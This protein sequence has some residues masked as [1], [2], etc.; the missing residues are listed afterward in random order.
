MRKVTYYLFFTGSALFLLFACTKSSSSTTLIGNWVNRFDFAG[1]SRTEAVAFTV[2][3]VAYIGTGYDGSNR[4]GD[5]WKYGVDN[6]TWVQV[7]GLNAGLERTSAV[8]FGTATKGYITT[9]LAADGVTKLKDTYEY[10]PVANTWTKKADF[11][12]TARYD[13]TAFSINNIGYVATG[14]DGNYTKDFYSYNPAT[15]TWTVKQGFQGFKRKQAVSFVYGGKGYVVTGIDNT[16][17]PNDF[18]V[19]D[20]TA[21]TWSQKRA[22]S[23]VSTDSYDDAYKIIRANAVAFVM[24]DFAYVTTGESGALFKDTW[25]YDFSKD[26]WTQKTDFEGGTR[27]GAV[28]FAVKGRGF[29]STGNVSSQEYSDFWEF[30]PTEAYNAND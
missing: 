30:H 29:I 17:Y 21:D 9:G 11:V 14:F 27:T 4:L 10:D 3:D 16:T 19:Y 20:P 5:F 25:E 28:A 23:N 18:W 1:V 8:A 6:N 26:I 22:I 2:G 15:D 13:A 7:A 12:G 24:G